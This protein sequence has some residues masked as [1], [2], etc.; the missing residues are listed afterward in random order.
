MRRRKR[1]SSEL[2]ISFS[3]N[4]KRKLKQET[5]ASPPLP[6][7]LPPSVALRHYHRRLVVRASS[8]FKNRSFFFL[9]L[10]ASISGI[11]LLYRAPAAVCRALS[12]HRLCLVVADSSNPPPSSELCSSPGLCL[13]HDSASLFS[14]CSEEKP[15]SIPVSF[16]RVPRAEAQPRKKP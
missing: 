10:G 4:Q 7:G 16:L 5:L 2:C 6:Q 8:S 14:D 9:E 12:H 11:H 13:C 3:P 15:I 1:K